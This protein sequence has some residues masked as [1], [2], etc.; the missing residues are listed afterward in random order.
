[1]PT[2][3]SRQGPSSPNPPQHRRAT[4]PID[5]RDRRRHAIKGLNP[6]Y[7]VTD[8]DS[9]A[10]EPPIRKP[11]V[12]ILVGHGD[13]AWMEARVPD[14]RPQPLGRLQ[15][16]V[17]ERPDFDAALLD[18][19]L[20]FWPERFRSCPS[21]AAVEGSLQDVETLDFDLGANR[22]PA[23]WV[24]LRREARPIYDRLIVVRL[25]GG[26]ARV[27]GS[28]PV[29]HGPGLQPGI[30]RHGRDLREFAHSLSLVDSF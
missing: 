1:M 19:L 25:D 6:I 16:I 9:P 29:R 11:G 3:E 13:R 5:S 22:I 27:C 14:G 7:V 2:G 23:E 12:A 20:A 26:L 21:L 28:L 10:S 4:E 17:P 24:A 18:A 8:P 30:Q 15:A